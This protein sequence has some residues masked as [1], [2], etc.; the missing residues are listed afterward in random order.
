M[1]ELDPHSGGAVI[2]AHRGKQPDD[3]VARIAGFVRHQAVHVR[4][5]LV[6]EE[7]AERV[8]DDGVAPVGGLVG[9]DGL[10]HVRVV[11]DNHRGAGVHD[12]VREVHILRFGGRRVLD[13]PVDGNHEEIALGAGRLD[14]RE[15]LGFV[16][17]RSARR[18]TGIGEE[19]DVREAVVAGIAVAVEPAR[20]AQPSHLD[21]VGLDDQRL[22]HELR[23]AGGAHREHAFGAQVFACLGKSVPTL[24]HHVVVG[25]GNDADAAGLEAVNQRH[26]GIELEGL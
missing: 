16:R 21:A 15:D 24:V 23:G 3:G 13:A 8:E 11:T 4:T 14:R 2:L 26:G 12:F 22:P 20:H 7:V 19:V 9:F 1:A 6:G 5:R 10:Q 18:L 17:A 25:E